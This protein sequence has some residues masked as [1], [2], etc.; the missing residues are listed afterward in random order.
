[1][2]PRGVSKVIGFGSSSFIGFLNES[3][4]LKY[5]RVK[6]EQWDR[7]DVESRIYKALGPH[8]RI[9]TFYGCDKRDLLRDPSRSR[10]LTIRNRIRFCQQ[11][12]EGIAYIHSKKVIHCDISTRNFL[13]DENLDVKL[14]DFQG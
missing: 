12:A 11:A 5:P 13:L 7:F 9:L 4:V 8:P 3:T 1:Y 2:Y 6:E 10:S 14:S